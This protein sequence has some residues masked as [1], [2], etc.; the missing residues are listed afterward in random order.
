MRMV[1][2]LAAVLL[3]FGLALPAL[4]AG[5]KGPLVVAGGE[6][7]FANPGWR[8]L[9]ELAG[10][11]GAPV[12]VVPTASTGPEAA[13]ARIV[14]H[15][16]SL[17]AAA[18]LLPL[19][20][21]GEGRA[22]A[23]GTASDPAWVARARAARGFYF[24]GGDQTR[25]TAALLRPDGGPTPLL[26]AI[27]AAHAGGAVVGGSS[28]GAAVM[29]DPMFREGPEP[30][31]ALAR[32]LEP[33][34]HT[35]RGLG[36]IG[37]GW[38]VDQHFL[39]RGRIGRM[40]VALRDLG[41]RRGVGVEEDTALVVTG[42]TAE[43]VG[44]KGVVLVDMGRARPAPGA[45]FRAENVLLS[46]A[47]AGDSIDLATGAVTPSAAKRAGAAIRPADPGFKPYWDGEAPA[48]Y[49]DMLGPG[50]LYEAMARTLDGAAG[51]ARG[52]AFGE[53]GR[54]GDDLGFEFT[55]SRTPD[56][57]GWFASG[58][59]YTVLNLRLDVRPVTMARPLYTPRD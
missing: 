28:A 52:I 10:G 11:A 59:W 4:A 25:I 13:G 43:V 24:T 8:R 27:R 47:A 17:G 5:P 9:V 22:D 49:S 55:L 16:K 26:E 19:Y 2:V 48:W 23:S 20:P 54:P 18:E 41:M 57:V 53:P 40:V 51:R 44:A 36:F 34:R 31:D 7:G 6:F 58:S 15:L 50:A 3:G 21:G 39:A 33:G 46:F 14:E 32:G 45:P 29:S 42:G 56:S 35:G 12:L 38:F 37:D 30:L 1:R